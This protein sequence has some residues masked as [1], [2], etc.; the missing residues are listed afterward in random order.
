MKK[1]A[2]SLGVDRPA[3]SPPSLGPRSARVRRHVATMVIAAFAFELAAPPRARAGEPG[4]DVPRTAEGLADEAYTELAAGKYAQA[5]ATYLRAYELSHAGVVFY[6]VAR[7]YDLKIHERALA[8]EYYRR[9]LGAPDAEPALVEKATERLT[10]LR[11]EA[12]AEPKAPLPSPPLEAP[13]PTAA[14]PPSPATPPSAAG[15]VAVQEPTSG[16]R[17]V[18]TAGI[19]VAAVGVVGV[20][21]SMVLGLLAKAKDNDANAVC[22]GKMCNDDRG[23]ALA[24]EGGRLGT[25]AT[26]SFVAGLALVGGGLTMYFIAPSARATQTAH[27]TI[28]PDLGPRSAGMIVVGSF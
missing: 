15:D 20:G 23:V 19:V 11:D 28:G 26:I 10:L 8:M 2:L 24:S 7:I 3:R 4:G 27:V 5:I 1:R 17:P 22:S 21:T 25:A 18:R 9:Y 12:D 13:A 6:N 14:P 16:G